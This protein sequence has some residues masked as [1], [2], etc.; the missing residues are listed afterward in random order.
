[1]IVRITLGSWEILNESIPSKLLR[2]SISTKPDG[3]YLLETASSV[4]H[5]V[6]CAEYQTNQEMTKY[7]IYD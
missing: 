2:P 7:L 4:Y 6:Y 3:Y 5:L 1:M